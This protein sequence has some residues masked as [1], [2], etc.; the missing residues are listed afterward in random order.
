MSRQDFEQ[1][2]NNYI[3]ELTESGAPIWALE[4]QQQTYEEFQYANREPEHT[5][6]DD[7]THSESVKPTY[8]LR[9]LYFYSQ[10]FPRGINGTVS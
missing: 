2:H 1:D 7:T 8:D 9:D 6:D 3:S 5:L 10:S 4:Q